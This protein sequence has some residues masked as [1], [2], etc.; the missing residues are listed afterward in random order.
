MAAPQ[1]IHTI[2]EDELTSVT[3]IEGQNKTD[4]KKTWKAISI[5][6]GDWSTLVFPK[7]KFEMDYILQQLGDRV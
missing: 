7:T 3:I 1:T 5:K 4:P 6:I 2:S